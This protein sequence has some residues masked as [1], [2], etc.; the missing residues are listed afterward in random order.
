MVPRG[1][2]AVVFVGWAS[3]AA[4]ASVRGTVML[5]TE[6]RI[7][8]H[9][10]HWRV[11]NGVLPLGPRVPDPHLDVIVVLEGAPNANAKV[12]NTVVELHGLRLDP[13]VT[14]VP[15]GGSVEFKNSDRVP[16]TLY[17]DRGT[18]LMPPA[19]TPSGQSR[20]QKFFAAGEYRIRDE[21]YPHVE[22]TI[23][24]LQ[25]PYFARL[26]EK[27]NFKLEVPEG[28]YT[29]KVFFRDKWVVSQPL[30]VAGRANEV[31]V[32]VPAPPPAGA[33]P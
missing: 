31:T 2:V 8:D 28:K 20:T 15:I 3:V 21:E 5:P 16:H 30:E 18:S 22:G 7:A 27:G 9:E 29:L 1:L 13:R 17:M 19:P 10:S 23:V 4:A 25:S 26:D 32:Q 6:P 24:V 11:E 33:K 12:P 14:V